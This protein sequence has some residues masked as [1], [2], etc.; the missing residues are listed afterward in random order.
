[1]RNF[2]TRFLIAS[3]FVLIL[4]WFVYATIFAGIPYQDPT[5]EMTAN[6]AFHSRVSNIILAFG[7][8]AL[9][10]GIV[11]GL[12]KL[13]LKKIGNMQESPE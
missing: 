3:G 10:I 5:P 2:P 7:L 11:G 1:M 12:S 9:L 8:G 13:L 6:Y 4:A